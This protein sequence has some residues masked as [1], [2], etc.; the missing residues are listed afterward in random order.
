MAVTRSKLAVT[1]RSFAT[2]ICSAGAMALG[3]RG[4]FR[5]ALAGGIAIAASLIAVLSVPDQAAA[6]G[7]V[8][9][10]VT[11]DQSDYQ[12]GETVVI[13][14]TG[15]IGDLSVHLNLLSDCGC[16]KEEWDAD[17][18]DAAAGTFTDSSFVVQDVHLGVTFTLVATG[19]PSGAVA[20]TTFTDANLVVDFKQSAN[21]D[22]RYG[23]GNIHW[24]G[25][26]VQGSNSTYFEGMS[27]LQ[28]LI[29]T[30][31]PA[32]PPTHVHR[33]SFAHDFTK[34]GIKAY[35]FLVSYDQAIATNEAILTAA[36]ESAVTYT[37][38]PCGDDIGPPADLDDTCD[39]LRN[40][41]NFATPSVPD[42]TYVLASTGKGSVSTRI[43]AYEG[44][45]GDRTVTIYANP[46]ASAITAS[47]SLPGSPASLPL[48]HTGPDTGDSEVQYVLTWT[49]DSSEILIEFAGHLAKSGD[50]D[51]DAEAWGPGN[52]ASFISGGPYHFVL[53]E[54]GE[55]TYSG[56]CPPNFPANEDTSLGNV[57]NQIKGADVL[58]ACCIP[59]QGCT[60]KTETECAQA[61]GTFFGG[62][63]DPDP[64]VGACCLPDGSC[65]ELSES[66][67]TAEFG[68]F[69]GG[70]TECA[71]VNCQLCTV[72]LCPEGQTFE[73]TGPVEDTTQIVTD[74]PTC[75]SKNC[76][77]DC[78]EDF[79]DSPFMPACGNAGAFYRTW[80]CSC[81]EFASKSCPPVLI[82]IVD[83]T[84]PDIDCPPD[85]GYKCLADV[86]ACDPY[87]A[88]ATDACDTFVEITC[89]EMNNG[90]SG[91]PLSPLIITR[92]YTATDDCEN[93][94]SC[95][96]II[97]VI[98]D[99]PPVLTGCPLVP[100][101]V[102]A[103]PMTCE[104]ILTLPDVTAD[105][106]CDDPVAVT[107]DAPTSFP[108][109]DTTVT[110]TADDSCG[111]TST[112]SV[113]VTVNDT[114][115]PVLTCTDVKV[116]VDA[117]ACTYASSQL[118][119]PAYFS[120]CGKDPD[121]SGIHNDAPLELPKGKTLVT[122][123][124]TDSNGL[125][126]TC[127][128]SVE[129]NDV[130]PPS[131]MCPPGGALSCNSNPTCE[132]VLAGVIA[133][134]T[135]K[136]VMVTCAVSY[137]SGPGCTHTRT[138]TVTADD[139][140]GNTSSC[141]VTFTWTDDT[142]G[143][144]ITCPEDVD[145]TCDNCDEE[146]LDPENTGYATTSDN[147]TATGD[148]VIDWDDEVSGTCPKI[149]TRTWT[150]EDACGNV[151]SCT[152]IIECLP[153][154]AV[155]SSSLCM[156]NFNCGGDAGVRDFRLILTP[157][158]QNGSN[159]HKL[160]ASNP[161]QFFYNVFY[162]GTPGSTATFDMEIP[163]P[164]VTQGAQPVHAYDG[165]SVEYEGT[166][167]CFVPSEYAF[168]VDSTQITL[169]GYM[170][171]PDAGNCVGFGDTA[172]ISVTLEVPDSGFVY[173]NVHLDYGL[174]GTSGYKKGT[175]VANACFGVPGGVV[176]SALNTGCA[177]NGPVTIA[178]FQQYEFSVDGD[179]IDSDT[180]ENC[181]N[182]KKN[183]GVGGLC[184][185]AGDLAPFFNGTVTLKK[186]SNNQIV[187]TGVS[188]VD[189]YYT[190][191]YKHTGPAAQYTVKFTTNNDEYGPYTV[192][193]T[194]QPNKFYYVPFLLTPP[195][196]PGGN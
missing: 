13:T 46:S 11:T 64:C 7:G 131:I 173:L 20:T 96:Q 78:D 147:C 134:D 33:I 137:D 65:E 73:C 169:A 47:F 150:A 98:D 133:S 158:P 24:I 184:Q 153:P 44:A 45:N 177:P 75:L 144:M 172:L 152:Q 102:D 170:D 175:S 165:V 156:F 40:G 124:V 188:D 106:N 110:W 49:S 179:V 72:K 109:G 8:V 132:Q 58:G 84:P 130:T 178:D 136:D 74:G 31:I 112:C 25:S 101:K 183:P 3:R 88:I 180:V 186:N 66:D 117:G 115:P 14:G 69:Q 53:G 154:S 105:D 125:T 127:V 103:D 121:A 71:D 163:Y 12:P 41:G 56:D 35:D 176:N 97:T 181:I 108:K 77:G 148:I 145:L 52:G 89:D 171:G 166:Q 126:G 27:N 120:F 194:M 5:V 116:N 34:G 57:D 28:R 54:L 196:A 17:N 18:F 10:T 192:I 59:G 174:K 160:N 119:P 118:A 9:P 82:T 107:N 135:C 1:A 167:A 113:T 80:T 138:F 4:A 111:N 79:E 19:V 23:L 94:A 99:V 76:T 22:A 182:F 15:W 129:V 60:G 190:I 93:S 95:E 155:T 67:C 195:A 104:A 70:G 140:N 39:L 36:Q 128:Q 149:I 42:D 83:T 38:N 85:A 142:T 151:S 141:D 26:I 189:G 68:E 185:L 191:N 51:V 92:T 62:S 87:A 122:W 6:G 63:C 157:D 159:C 32:N 55:D 50:P 43:A 143:P 139:G 21:N 164:F 187:G 2:R 161:G 29:I 81:G 114:N 193:I 86:P 91:C 30:G 90:G 100:I 168:Y 16:T 37:L 48:C 162:T 61:G 146:A 123:T